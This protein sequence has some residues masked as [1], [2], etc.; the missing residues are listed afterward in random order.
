MVVFKY[1]EIL[2]TPADLNYVKRLVGLP[3]ETVV[4]KDGVLFSTPGPVIER[5]PDGTLTTDCFRLEDAP[6]P[7]AGP[8]EVVVRTISNDL[9][10]DYTAVGQS[11]HLASRMEQLSTPGTIFVTADT[12]RLVEGLIELHPMGPTPVKAISIARGIVP[13]AAR[14]AARPRRH[15]SHCG[16]RRACRV[17]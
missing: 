8:G 4:L 9:R 10:M 1:P 2:R 13:G 6:M 17:H 14:I 11:T 16:S 5:L 12:A 7:V 15:L 3:G